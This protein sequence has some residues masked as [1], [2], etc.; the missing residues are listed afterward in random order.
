M[1][2]EPKRE[3]GY[4]YT[5]C[6]VNKKTGVEVFDAILGDPHNYINNCM[7]AGEAGCIVKKS[8]WGDKII[9]LFKIIVGDDEHVPVE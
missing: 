7:Q 9:E 4:K 3:L 1:F 8:P 5:I 2:D 6:S